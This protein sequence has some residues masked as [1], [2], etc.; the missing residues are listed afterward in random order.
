MEVL[1]SLGLEEGGERKGEAEMKMRVETCRG[2][3][4]ETSEH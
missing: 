2:K 1:K 4:A 3:R